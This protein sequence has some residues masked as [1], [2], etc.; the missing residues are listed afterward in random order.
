MPNK[1]IHPM[2]DPSF[3][4]TLLVDY[5][6]LFGVI[7]E[8]AGTDEQPDSVVIELIKEVQRHVQDHLQLRTIR[9]VAFASLPPGHVQG[10]RATGAWLA[11]GIEPRFSHALASD[12]ATTIDLAMEAVEIAVAQQSPHAYIILSGN[13]WFVPLVQRLQKKGHFVVMASL[14]SPSR[15]DHFPADVME[16]F[17][18]VRFLLDKT[19]FPG[20]DK[21]FDADGERPDEYAGGPA[22]IIP[23]DDDG[24]RQALEVIEQF[25]G[26]YE[27][28]Y[29]TPLLRK[30]SEVLGDAEEPKELVT[31]LEECG[32]VWLEK[33][34]GFPHNYTVLLVNDEHPDVEDVREHA[35]AG[36]GPH[37]DDHYRDEEYEDDRAADDED[38]DYEEPHV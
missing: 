35:A 38:D 1:K 25:F 23:L 14:E 7:V 34:R 32:A 31:I 30:L 4:A 5:T 36:T 17:L 8:R 11:S 2:S 19:T 24:A 13:Q 28:V 6:N 9:T 20:G 10:H 18:N 21:G 3:H 37:Y 12:E 16:A 29:L 33:R 27:E 15:S 26:Q 22:E